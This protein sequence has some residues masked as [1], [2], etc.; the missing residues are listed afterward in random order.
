MDRV[1]AHDLRRAF[2]RES[3]PHQVT[4]ASAKSEATDTGVADDYAG[5]GQ[6]ECLALP[7]EIGVQATASQL[8]GSSQWIDLLYRDLEHV[9]PWTAEA[10]QGRFELFGV[11][12]YLCGM[13]SY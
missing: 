8:N 3:V 10:E 13:P 9:E 7:V 12:G 4:V 11:P 6:P 1:S 5:G 2:A